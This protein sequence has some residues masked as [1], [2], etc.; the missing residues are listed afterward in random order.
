MIFLT[1]K[2]SFKIINKRNYFILACTQFHSIFHYK[3]SFTFNQSIKF[4]K[5]YFK[6]NIK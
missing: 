3:N 4:K 2:N 5:D 1:I 6:N